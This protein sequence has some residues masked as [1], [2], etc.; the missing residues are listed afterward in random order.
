MNRNALKI[1]LTTLLV[2]GYLLLAVGS[3]W[4]VPHGH[5]HQHGPRHGAQTC[6][7]CLAAATFIIL[8]V[9]YGVP[10]LAGMAAGFVA[11]VPI[12]PLSRLHFLGR[13]SRAP[14]VC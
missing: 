1:I 8:T 6:F 12:L 11:V 10:T 9:L 14:P 3:V 5:D 7:W 13:T 4:H 2:A